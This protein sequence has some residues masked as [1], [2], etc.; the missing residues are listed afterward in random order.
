MRQTDKT[1]EAMKQA[2][3]ALQG[4]GYYDTTQQREAITTLRAAIAE[5]S[6]QDVQQAFYALEN[7]HEAKPAGI[8]N[9]VAVLLAAAAEQQ[10]WSETEA[11]RE[12]LREHMAEI[13]RLKS[14]L[15]MQRLTD[16]QQEMEHIGD[17]NKMVCRE[18]VGLTDEEID[19]MRQNAQGLNF[20]TFREFC[21]ISRAIEA[22]LKEKNYD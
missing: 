17:A 8:E 22:K 12:S 14:E 5:A 1:I 2:L 16:V 9:A 19:Y 6:G 20:V 7:P 10:D 4:P 13:H 21:I 15:A 3:E 18:W 11:L